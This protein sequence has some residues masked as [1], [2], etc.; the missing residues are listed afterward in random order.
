VSKYLHPWWFIYLI[1]FVGCA[2]MQNWLAVIWC[3]SAVM[4]YS[5][6]VA[7]EEKRNRA[8]HHSG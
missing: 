4:A 2:V 7:D 5:V 6:G 8:S 1:G 3:V